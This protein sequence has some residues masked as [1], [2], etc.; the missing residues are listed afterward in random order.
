MKKNR[1]TLYLCGVLALIFLFCAA[2]AWAESAAPALHTIAVPED[3]PTSLDEEG[4]D[5]YAG[6][7]N[8]SDSAYYVIKDYYNM[9]SGG[10]LH[11]LSHFDTYQQTTEYT[12]GP[13]TALMVLHWFGEDQYDEMQIGEM[14]EIDM[15]KGTSVEGL[16]AVFEALGWEVEYH[17]DTDYRFSSDAEWAAYVIEHIDA[18]IP[19]MV[20]WVDWGGHWQAVIGLDSCGTEEPDD[21]VLILAD[22]YDTTDHCQDGFYTYPL[23]RFYYL[24]FEGPC[25]QKTEPYNQPFVVAVPG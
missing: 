1:T 17:A 20:D 5:A 21:D 15:D 19:I 18:G 22:P 9:V 13:A 3:Y 2:S 25:A 14:A 23:D 24:W 16:A 12:C 8:H 11:I 10:D 4:A 6:S 7:M